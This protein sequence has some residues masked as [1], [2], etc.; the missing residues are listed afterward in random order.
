M[1]K[2]F[3][4]IGLIAAV[5]LAGCY[6]DKGNVDY[7]PLSKVEISGIESAYT[8]YLGDEWNVPVD[9]KYSL[10][11]PEEVAYLWKV[12]GD[13][14]ATTKDLD[15]V[16]SF[17]LQENMTAEYV[18]T[19]L[20]NG[21]RT[22]VPF[23]V[24]VKSEFSQGWMILS[25]QAE[26][27]VLGYFR[28]GDGRFYEDIYSAI[29]R[30]HLSKGA[31][32]LVEH[33]LSPFEP[34]VT[35]L[36]GQI[37]VACTEGPDYSVDLD[38]D[39]FERVIYTKEE[40]V[41]ALPADFKPEVY[42]SMPSPETGKGFDYLISNSK[43]YTRALYDGMSFQDGLYTNIPYDFN[44]GDYKLAPAILRGNIIWGDYLLGF[45]NV[46]GSFVQLSDGEVLALDPGADMA[47]GFSMVN[48]GLTWID[49]GTVAVLN[50]I[51]GT[52]DT[53]VTFMKDD[54]G[55]VMVM[56]F[57]VWPK[58]FMGSLVYLSMVQM[59]FCDTDGNPVVWGGDIINENTHFAYCDKGNRLYIASGNKLY[60][61]DHSMMT[62]SLL[63][64]Y[65][66]PIVEIGMNRLNQMELGIAFDNGNGTSDF[67]VADVS[68]IGGG[69]IKHG[70]LY[71]VEGKVKDILY[72]VGNQLLISG[73]L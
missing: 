65:D 38:G 31:S 57:Q 26:H 35:T 25:E 71:T 43:V 4:H 70:K 64:I 28:D 29:N 24:T 34:S 30:E 67:G 47:G 69:E 55:N 63:K 42:E 22:I 72:K 59:P 17:P 56:N 50:D 8:L 23:N 7:K 27:S 48:T 66:K 49:G 6:K 16:V 53:Y 36:T 37:F 68:Y 15:V 19:D 62:L 46:S 18:V 5:L 73:M 2:L 51:E 60:A 40:F 32:R 14:I 20:S 13:T 33:F 9:I 45:D 41:G 3:I 44:G 1:N 54:E 58:M 10:D 21:V 11:T 39:S 61:F 12:N 52:F